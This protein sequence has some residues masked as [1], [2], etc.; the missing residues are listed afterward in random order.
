MR[1]PKALL[2]LDGLP[3]VIKGL[4]DAIGGGVHRCVVTV[5]EPPQDQVVREV[6]KGEPTQVT[7][8]KWPDAGLI[9]SIRT[10][11]ELLDPPGD[12]LLVSPVDCPFASA[13]LC[14]QLTAVAAP[15]RIVAPAF[16]GRLGHPIVFGRDWFELLRSPAADGGAAALVQRAGASLHTVAWTDPRILAD[17]NTFEMA[18]GLGVSRPPTTQSFS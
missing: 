4:R 3:L 7:R 9:G 1:F 16:E 10:A 11:L 2:E 14:Q 15:E 5:P 13:D 17:I 8:N 18:R 6:L 12:A